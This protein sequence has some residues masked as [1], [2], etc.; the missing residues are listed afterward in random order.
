MTPERSR[1]A[2]YLAGT[3]VLELTRIMETGVGEDCFS[4]SRP[5][6]LPRSLEDGLRSSRVMAFAGKEML[7]QTLSALSPENNITR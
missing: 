4:G 2:G 1:R 6:P 3:D 5:E 7:R